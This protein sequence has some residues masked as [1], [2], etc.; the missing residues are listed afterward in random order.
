MMER[1]QDL[2]DIKQS[3]S[4]C[5][6]GMGVLVDDCF[7]QICLIL[8]RKPDYFCDN[9]PAKWG[10][11]FHGVMCI[12]PEELA[13][14]SKD[15]LVIITVRNYEVIH[16]QLKSLNLTNIMV[17]H[18]E[19][20][21]NR[22]A[23]MKAI[24]ANELTRS[25]ST[26]P[27][28]QGKWALVTGAS[29]GIGFQIATA[30][31][32]LGLNIVAHSRSQDHNDNVIQACQE[33]GVQTLSFSADLSDSE[34]VKNMISQLPE[35][36]I[37]INSAGVSLACDDFWQVDVD[38]FIE[39]YKI[40]TIAPIML[41]NALLP[42]MLARGFGRILTVSS[43]IQHRPYEMAYACSKA[44]LDKYVHDIVPSL[45]DADVKMALLDPGWVK[46]DM[47][48][49]AALHDV[50]TVLPGAILGVV[51][52][53]YENGHWFSAQDYAGY[54]LNAAIEKARNMAA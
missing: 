11:K 36:D 20:G 25:V 13:R 51:M 24:A 42:K 10:Q 34:Q 48:G 7:D 15:T 37:L 45:G 6:F 21:L 53:D 17:C 39:T 54:D 2:A 35:V 47:G 38:A 31:A 40:N 49:K 32:R 29:R 33:E 1:V 44:A 16:R 8:G 26:Q 3:T 46:T 4:I 22:I 52:T 30:L 28:L 5:L 9:Q 43:S 27:N 12:S 50:E 23:A 14:L 41:S 18:F 19:R